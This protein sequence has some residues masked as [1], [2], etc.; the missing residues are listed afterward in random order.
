LVKHELAK[1]IAEQKGW[2]EDDV[3]KVLD[4]VG[5]IKSPAHDYA[6]NEDVFDLK[7]YPIK[8]AFDYAW[9]QLANAVHNENISFPKEMCEQYLRTIYG[10]EVG[11]EPVFKFYADLLYIRNNLAVLEHKSNMP[12]NPEEFIC[13]IEN[14]FENIVLPEKILQPDE[15]RKFKT[16][17]TNI[18]AWIRK[19]DEEKKTDKNYSI[20]KKEL[21][22]IRGGLKERIKA[23]E[24]FEKNGSGKTTIKYKNPYTKLTNEFKQISSSY[25]KTFA[26]LRD[27]FKE[28]NEITKITHFGIIIEDSNKDRYLLA[29]GLQHGNTNQDSNQVEA[30]LEKLGNSSE[31]TTYQVKSLTSKTLIKLIKN[32]TIKDGAKSPYADFHT[33]K[34]IDEW[35]DEKK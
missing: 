29:N 24:V 14:T 33:S 5:A 13:K 9:E 22:Q 18:L 27:K 20:A 3:V 8:V 15:I 34:I 31:F 16:S 4:A 11:K 35:D 32:H 12:S 19:D 6:H 25:G 23:R 21:G 30:I 28:K 2:S 1:Y 10:Y 26:E 17:K 7:H